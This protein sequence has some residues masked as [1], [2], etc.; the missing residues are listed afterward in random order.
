[1]VGK[2]KGTVLYLYIIL[3]GGVTIDGIETF[4]HVSLGVELKR[5]EDG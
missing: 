3:E 5:A 2:E 1:M 4:A